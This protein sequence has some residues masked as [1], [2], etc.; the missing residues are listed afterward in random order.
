[1]VKLFYLF[2]CVRIRIIKTKQ[3]LQ[4]NNE[5]KRTHNWK[6]ASLYNKMIL[7]KR[8]VTLQK[9]KFKGTFLKIKEAWSRTRI[10]G[11]LK[12]LY[13]NYNFAVIYPWNLSFSQKIAYL[14][15]VSFVVS[16]Y[17]QNFTAQ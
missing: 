10:K 13:Y 15:M 6:G 17:K 7:M 16:V 1:M 5:R 8:G 9:I 2:V 11:I 3:T 12:I 14:L 4:G